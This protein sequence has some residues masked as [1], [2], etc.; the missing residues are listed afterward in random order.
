LSAGCDS[1]WMVN[2]RDVVVVDRYHRRL[3]PIDQGRA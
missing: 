3:P 2:L 1:F